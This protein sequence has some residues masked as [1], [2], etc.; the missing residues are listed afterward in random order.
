[1]D[2]SCCIL[3]LKMQNYTENQKKEVSIFIR[4]RFYLLTLIPSSKLN[5]LLSPQA[6]C[7]KTLQVLLIRKKNSAVFE[8]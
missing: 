2:C 6:I 4:G 5:Q 8:A 1:M 7:H 3:D